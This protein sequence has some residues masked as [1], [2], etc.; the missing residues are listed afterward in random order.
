MEIRMEER[1]AAQ[2]EARVEAVRHVFYQQLED[3]RRCNGCMSP[4]PPPPP[5][6]PPSPSPP[7][8]SP[9]PIVYSSCSTAV[10]KRAQNRVHLNCADTDGTVW[11]S[12]PYTD[13]S[14]LG[15]AVTHACGT[16]RPI[17]VNIVDLGCASSFAATRSYGITTIAWVAYCNAMRIDCY[18]VLPSPPPSPP[19]PWP[20]PYP[21]DAA[22]Q[23]PSPSPPSPSPSSAETAMAA[24]ATEKA[25]AAAMRDGEGGGG[26]D[27]GGGGGLSRGWG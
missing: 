8:P 21:A 5:P 22:P 9:P 20:L 12:N 19:P 11:G 2:L 3:I 1:Y 26:G 27:G 13:D 18:S 16:K 10:G 7:S 15:R 24:A 6:P 23:P 25:A 4:S 14:K 17:S